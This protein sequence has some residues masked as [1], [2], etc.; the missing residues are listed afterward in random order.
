M[1]IAKYED[2]CEEQKK[3]SE[4]SGRWWKKLLFWVHWVCNQV[5]TCRSL[6][7]AQIKPCSRT[8][9]HDWTECPF[10]H[11]GEAA[12]RRD[13]RQHPYSCLPC[14]DF[15]KGACARGETCECRATN[16]K[17]LCQGGMLCVA[18]PCGPCDGVQW[19]SSISSADLCS[20][21]TSICRVLASFQAK[22]S[23]WC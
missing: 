16:Q 22:L 2:E 9:S 12:R 6:C 23:N 13:P 10:A 8:Y 4:R 11:P 21:R 5:L 14:P 15:R 18:K 7:G 20:Q 17:T 19:L 3:T 1:A